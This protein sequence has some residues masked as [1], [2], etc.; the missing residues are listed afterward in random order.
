M[1]SRGRDPVCDPTTG[2]PLADVTIELL[3]DDGSVVA[4]TSTNVAG[5]YEFVHLR[6]G[7]YT[8]RES[9]PAGYFHGGQ[10]AGS[11]GGDDSQIDLI[12]AIQIGAGVELVDYNFCEL[13]PATISGHVFQDGSTITTVDGEI[14]ENLYEIRD[15]RRT[16]DDTPIA[17]VELELRHGAT[18][19][20][21]MADQALD[22]I[23]AEGPIRTTTDASGYYEFTDCPAET[24]PSTKSIRK[25]TSTGSTRLAQ[26]VASLSIQTA[27]LTSESCNFWCPTEQRCDYLDPS[28]AGTDVAGKQFQ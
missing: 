24:T 11:G 6:P 23:Y 3:A 10:S 16:A 19:D 21:I 12:S 13:P 27:K 18:G 20:P 5:A 15:G 4:T 1:S 7:T 22:G 25:L 14:P 9:Q 8:V 26:P 2:E 28:C 17:Q